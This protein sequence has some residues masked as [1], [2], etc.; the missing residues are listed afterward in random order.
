MKAVI[1]T[2]AELSVGTVEAP[3]PGRGQLVLDDPVRHLRI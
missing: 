3:S 2:K 1:L